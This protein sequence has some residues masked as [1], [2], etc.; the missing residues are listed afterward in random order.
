MLKPAIVNRDR[1]GDW[2]H[3]ALA[4]LFG[5]GENEREIIPGPEW[6]AWLADH[7][8][9]TAIVG[10]EAELDDD[11]PAWIR[12]FDEGEPGSVGWHPEP[13]GPEWHLLSIHDTED[14]PVAIWYREIPAPK[15]ESL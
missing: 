8:I 13:P 6:K 10:M 12:H 7:G 1:Y 15:E 5:Q 4:A 14:G 2:T 9:E 3:P 11:H